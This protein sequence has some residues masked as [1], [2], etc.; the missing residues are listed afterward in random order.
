MTTTPHFVTPT[1][2]PRPPKSLLPISV[3]Q[4]LDKD[5]KRTRKRSNAVKDAKKTAIIRT[6]HTPILE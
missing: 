4:T 1:D 3:A 5:A 6:V 2:A